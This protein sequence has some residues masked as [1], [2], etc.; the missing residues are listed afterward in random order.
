MNLKKKF[1]RNLKILKFSMPKKI[2]PKSQV[3]NKALFPQY[4]FLTI[5]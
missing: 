2:T 3:K 1:S 5:S 4:P